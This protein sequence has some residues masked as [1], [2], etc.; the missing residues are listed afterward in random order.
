MEIHAIQG[1][2]CDHVLSTHCNEGDDTPVELISRARLAYY[3]ALKQVMLN[4]IESAAAMLP[5][6]GS[7]SQIR[8]AHRG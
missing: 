5:A 7:E 2:R 3:I 4:F 8:S 1:E 6:P